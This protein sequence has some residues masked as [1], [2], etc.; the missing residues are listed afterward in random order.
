MPSEIEVKYCQIQSKI[1]AIQCAH[2]VKK[3][4]IHE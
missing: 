2:T 1:V 3:A 4:G